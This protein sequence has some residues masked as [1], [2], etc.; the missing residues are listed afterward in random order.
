MAISNPSGNWIDKITLPTGTTYIIV[1]TDARTAIDNLTDNLTSYSTFLGVTTT[2]LT[3]GSTAA[4]ITINNQSI[5]ATKGDIVIKG[6]Q[7]FIFDGGKWALFGDLSALTNTLGNLAYYNSATGTFTPQG[8]ITTETATLTFAGSFTPNG[9]VNLTTSTQTFV[10]N[11]IASVPA[12]ATTANYWIYTPEGNITTEATRTLTQ[13][14]VLNNIEGNILIN[15]I[16]LQAP[17]SN[18]GTALNY[19]NVATHT[20]ILSS[21]LPSTTGAIKS[22]SSVTAVTDVSVTASGSFGGTEVVVAPIQIGIPTSAS[23][24]GTGATI[25][26]TGAAIN[27]VTFTGTPATIMVSAAAP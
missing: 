6:S 26:V 9:S 8:T 2:N 23:F 20:L 5:T 1:D 25:S 27:S 11:K 15:N 18:I 21:L 24:S 12:G 4:V 13:Q 14:A 19:T 10:I 7:E 3:D 22:T 17:T 16:Q